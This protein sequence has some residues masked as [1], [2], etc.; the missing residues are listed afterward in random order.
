MN[1]IANSWR[2]TAAG[3]LILKLQ[4]AARKGIICCFMPHGDRGGAGPTELVILINGGF[5]LED[6]TPGYAGAGNEQ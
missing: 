2:I 5:G 1:L 3:K 6:I 4:R